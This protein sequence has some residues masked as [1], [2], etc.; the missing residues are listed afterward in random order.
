MPR[1]ESGV[2]WALKVALGCLL[3]FAGAMKLQDPAA[4]A[5]EIAN[6]QF[7]P[8]LASLAASTLPAT[9]VAVGLLLVFLPPRQTWL[10]A[11]ALASSVM[12]LVFTVAVSQVVVRGI[13]TS[14]GCFGSGSGNVDGWTIARVV[15][16]FAASLAV[17]QLGRRARLDT[18]T[19][20]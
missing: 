4:F 15:A 16:L 19:A 10:H 9:E 13:D 1:I 5:S 12:M 8:A 7:L 20:A 14:C 2:A 3:I 18:A 17:L 11:A 6:Y